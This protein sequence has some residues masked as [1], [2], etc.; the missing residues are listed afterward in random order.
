ML[1]V[2]HLVAVSHSIVALWHHSRRL[3]KNQHRDSCSVFPKASEGNRRTEIF[4][5]KLTGFRVEFPF[6]LHTWYDIATFGC[7][8]WLFGV[9]L[10]KAP[11]SQPPWAKNPAS[12]RS[13]VCCPH[14]GK[15]CR[16]RWHWQMDM[17]A[18]GSWMQLECRIALAQ[19]L[20]KSSSENREAT[21]SRYRNVATIQC[22]TTLTRPQREKDMWDDFPKVH[23]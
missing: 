16:F 22:N 3:P 17:P 15:R 23:T 7:L 9:L 4:Q 10:S 21:S 18:W 13:A 11:P 8:R 19:E 14:F 20:T 2:F 5:F 12:R 1:Y 6:K